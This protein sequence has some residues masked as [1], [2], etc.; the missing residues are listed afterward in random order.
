GE[1]ARQAG[2]GG[3]PGRLGVYIPQAGA[4]R[5]RKPGHVFEQRCRFDVAAGLSSWKTR[6]LKP[7]FPEEMPPAT[8][9]RDD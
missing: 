9:A 4:L 6:V 3:G 7:C 1:A 2:E 8:D 5:A